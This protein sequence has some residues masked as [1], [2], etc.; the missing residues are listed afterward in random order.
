MKF[1][2][3]KIVAGHLQWDRFEPGDFYRPGASGFNGG[4]GPG[5]CPGVHFRRTRPWI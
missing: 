4:R 5:L 1:T 3:R 2:V